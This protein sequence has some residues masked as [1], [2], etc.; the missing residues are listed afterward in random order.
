[1]FY[2]YSAGSS[3]TNNT[4]THTLRLPIA[5]NVNNF[6]SLSYI[7]PI[8]SGLTYPLSYLIFLDE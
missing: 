2:C 4:T 3:H 5:T 1:M 6:N 8:V 7:F